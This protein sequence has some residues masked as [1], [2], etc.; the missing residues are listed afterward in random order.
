MRSFKWN[1]KTYK[2]HNNLL[3]DYHGADGL[4]TGYIRASG[5]NL[6]ASAA[7]GDRRVIGVIFGSRNAKKRDRR[8]ASLLDLGFKRAQAFPLKRVPL[9]RLKPNGQATLAAS[10][11]G[12]MVPQ[13]K[14][15]ELEIGA[16][17]DGSLPSPQQSGDIHWGIQV[18]AFH[19]Y[20]SAQ[21][22]V[23]LATSAVPQLLRNRQVVIDTAK[24]RS[25]PLYRARLYG[26]DRT[27]AEKAC[28]AL[29]ARSM[30]CLVIAPSGK[31]MRV[32]RVGS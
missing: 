3:D 16:A 8:M 23:H 11:S 17:A 31:T 30:G 15:A 1:G 20:A 5:F 22:Q 4:K 18:G 12:G 32:A 27:L 28:D 7:R 26:F 19:R 14:P 24:R 6:I 2:T 29:K 25:G 21:A 13:L 9:P 10:D